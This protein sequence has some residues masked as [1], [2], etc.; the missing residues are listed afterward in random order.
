MAEPLAEVVIP[1]R[2]TFKSAEVCDLLK[3]QPYVLRSWENEF[4]DL[5]AA[6]TTGRVYRR[7][8]VERAVR[9]RQLVFGEG[10]T[11]A[12]V[13]RRLDA[14]R[15]PEPEPEPERPAAAPATTGLS[16]DMRA[17]IVRARDELRG[18]L[19]QLGGQPPLAAPKRAAEE[20]ALE[21]P[22][23]VHDGGHQASDTPQPAR[24]RRKKAADGAAP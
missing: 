7:G 16:S 22:R 13:R 21:P 5:G 24:T 18:L 1:D 11:L 14:E 6:G 20:F 17:R 9:I 4:K 2:Q 19:T 15:P 8:D 10:L 3:V 23:P 12:G